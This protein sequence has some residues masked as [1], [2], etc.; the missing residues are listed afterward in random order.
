M[1]YSAEEV[2]RHIR[3]ARIAKGLNQRELGQHVKCDAGGVSRIE[4]GKRHLRI[5]QAARLSEVLGLDLGA[6]LGLS[7]APNPE[8]GLSAELEILADRL[9]AVAKSVNDH[10]TTGPSRVRAALDE[11]VTHGDLTPSGRVVLLRILDRVA[12]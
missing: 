9:S 8:V 1:K 6:V 3:E 11:L 10:D 12:S 2:G 5:D 4:A 7:V